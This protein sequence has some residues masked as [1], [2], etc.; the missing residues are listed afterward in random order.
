MRSLFAASILAIALAAPALA[1]NAGHSTSPATATPAKD[2][3]EQPVKDATQAPKDSAAAAVQATTDAATAAGQAVKDGARATGQAI[4]NAATATGAAIANA[5]AAMSAKLD[6][7]KDGWNLRHGVIDQSVY[8]EKNTRIGEID[9]VVLTGDAGKGYHVYAVVGVG[10]FLGIGER[11]VA[12]PIESLK[13]VD[14]KF[15]M[16]GVTTESLGTWP[17]YKYVAPASVHTTTA[18]PAPAPKR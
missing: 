18:T 3:V 2:K 4:S 8:D 9:D 14:G 6:D 7:L 17:E 10:G 15:V 16:P 11:K 1:Q 12:T 13:K 5:G